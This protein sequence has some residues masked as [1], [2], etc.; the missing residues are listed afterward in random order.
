MT[1]PA[2]EIRGLRKTFPVKGGSVT[3]VDGLDLTV[4]PGEIVAFLGPNGAGKTTTLDM[5]LGLTTPTAGTVR[6]YGED[7][8]RA[9]ADG[10]VS[11]VLQ[12]GGLLDDLTVG[13]TVRLIASTYRRHQPV[14]SVLQQA[15]IT[16]LRDRRVLKCSGG[17]QQRLRF[18]LA[19]LP[20][21]DL[22]ILDEPTA[23][24][25]VTARQEFW[26]TMHADAEVGRT[27]VFATH[28]LEEAEDFARR[29]FLV[30]GGRVVADGTTAELRARSSARLVSADIDESRVAA[31]QDL[32]GRI[33]GVQHVGTTGTSRTG[34]RLVARCTD[35]DE[36][37]RALLTEGA[38]ELE[39]SR[40]SLDQTFLDLTR[41]AEATT[42]TGTQT[43]GTTTAGDP[44]A[45][46]P[47]AAEE[48]LR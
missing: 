6:T 38:T 42:T 15:G 29:I 13:E 30:A 8:R 35:S 39:V 33:L 43:A 32:V 47:R 20:S 31:V 9:V 2:I 40:G 46:D 23:G 12:S 41:Q 28:Y 24:M 19:L 4:E 22:L 17:E 18:A 7:P 5:V 48:A 16:R 3:A 10:R 1:A 37:A 11:A 44:A 21:P 34:I 14:E 27:V 36:V 25:D 45:P 26:A